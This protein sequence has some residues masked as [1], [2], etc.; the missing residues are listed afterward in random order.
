MLLKNTKQNLI[1]HQ[2]SIHLSI[3]SLVSFDRF[4]LNFQELSEPSLERFKS[5]F[6]SLACSHSL[7]LILP[8]D[9]K[10]L[11]VFPLFPMTNCFPLACNGDSFKFK[12]VFE[13][14][15]TKHRD[16][17]CPTSL[18]TKRETFSVRSQEKNW[19]SWDA[20]NCHQKVKEE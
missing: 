1:I 11:H 17:L 5:I 2:M 14:L 7:Y 8:F 15:L 10:G 9:V 19:K 18:S 3:Y 4:Q 13:R 12:S 16:K 20:V 6:R